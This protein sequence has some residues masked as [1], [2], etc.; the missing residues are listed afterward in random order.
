[1]DG[2]DDIALSMEKIKDIDN[3]EKIVEKDKP[4]IFKNE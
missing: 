3:F 2:L 4:W 1:M